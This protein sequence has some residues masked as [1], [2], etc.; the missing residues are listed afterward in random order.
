MSRRFPHQGEL[1]LK[2]QRKG[3]FLISLMQEEHLIKAQKKKKT[4]AQEVGEQL[5][6]VGGGVVNVSPVVGG[7]AGGAV[8]RG[9]VVQEV[10]ELLGRPPRAVEAL[11]QHSGKHRIPQ[12]RLMSKRFLIVVRAR[13]VVSEE[14]AWRSAV[15]VILLQR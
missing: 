11:I 2:C 12:Q 4:H 1:Y 5:Q 10:G 8:L 7:H 3:Y 6:D 9:P 14:E 15:T 13:Q